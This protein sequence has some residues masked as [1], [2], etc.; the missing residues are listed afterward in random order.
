MH[1][2]DAPRKEFSGGS[3]SY[4]YD[5]YSKVFSREYYDHEAMQASRLQAIET[6][7]S[8]RRWGLI[9]GTLGRQ[10]NPKILEHLELKLKA[11]GRL[12]TRVL[13]SEI[14]PNKLALMADVDA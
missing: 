14:F 2:S 13:L 3:P 5:P 9:L 8:A 1:A 10:G 7:R 4:R 11:L 12:F 6:A